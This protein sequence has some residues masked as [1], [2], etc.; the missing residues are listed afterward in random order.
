ML[1]MEPGP[2]NLAVFHH[3]K[4]LPPPLSLTDSLSL[5]PPVCLSI[6]LFLSVCVY[7]YLCTR[8]TI[9]P[10]PKY[11]QVYSMGFILPMRYHSLPLLHKPIHTLQLNK[12]QIASSVNLFSM[13]KTGVIVISTHI[14]LSSNIE[15]PTHYIR[16]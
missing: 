4:S 15:L 12:P 11:V 14:E 6:F 5:P 9:S 7:L 8:P 13:C 16:N 2:L 1:R 3:K 10:N